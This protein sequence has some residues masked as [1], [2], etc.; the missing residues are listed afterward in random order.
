MEI[1]QISKKWKDQYGVILT[2]RKNTMTCPGDITIVF[3]SFKESSC[4]IG[5]SLKEAG[6]YKKA[7]ETILKFKKGIN[8]NTSS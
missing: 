1:E 2:D 3:L 6:G 8:K 5:E 7:V 4:K